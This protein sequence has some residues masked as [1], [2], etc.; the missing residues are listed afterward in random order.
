[1]AQA[2]PNVP[3]PNQNDEFFDIVKRIGAGDFED[4]DYV[5]YGVL[6]SLSQN[7]H[8]APILG[9]NNEMAIHAL[10]IAV[11]FSLIDTKTHQVVASFLATGS[12]SD[13]R[14]DG[15]AEGYKP[16][17]PRM[18]QQM[19]TSLAESVA[20]QLASQDFVTSEWVLS[21]KESREILGT[22]KYRNEERHLRVY[23]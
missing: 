17:M 16:S 22:E 19:A 2:K 12:A 1:V 15:V 21:G 6:T 23:K 3:Q 14:I 4:A 11:D 13:S 5:L 20:H 10:E 9:S 7:T 18:F 8:A